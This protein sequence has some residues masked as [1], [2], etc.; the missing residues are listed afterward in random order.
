VY[1]LKKETLKYLC[2]PKCRKESFSIN[3]SIFKEVERGSELYEGT[4]SCINCKTGFPVIF[5]IPVLYDDF[6]SYLSKEKHFLEKIVYKL[7]ASQEVRALIE[8]LPEYIYGSGVSESWGTDMGIEIYAYNQYLCQKVLYSDGEEALYFNSFYDEITPL[9][10][11]YALNNDVNF[12]IGCNSG[13]VLYKASDFF[14]YSIGV[15]VSLRAILKAK[16]ISSDIYEDISLSFRIYT[17]ANTYQSVQP[18]LLKKHNVDFILCDKISDFL[19]SQVKY[20]LT[21]VNTLDILREP[22]EFAR[23]L[24]EKIPTGSRLFITT[25]YY[26]RVDRSKSSEWLGGKDDSTSLATIDIFKENLILLQ[27][28][29]K[30]WVLFFY[31]RYFQY[32]DCDIFTFEKL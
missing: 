28:S 25:P 14:P 10:K 7:G 22:K 30:P 32:W 6:S 18:S 11:K 19:N 15:D 17:D 8:D 29:R 9:I 12:E 20:H 13:G 3:G 31:P 21:I 27:Q 16:H 26:W 2:C 4:I 24:I 23:A 1:P 5:G